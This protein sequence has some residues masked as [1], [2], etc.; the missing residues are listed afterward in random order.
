MLLLCYQ[1]R[2][3]KENRWYSTRSLRVLEFIFA[4]LEEENLINELFSPTQHE[5]HGETET[6]G[7]RFIAS[8]IIAR[9]I[10]AIKRE[11]LM[12]SPA[13]TPELASLQCV[14]FSELPPAISDRARCYLHFLL[15]GLW[16]R[17]RWKLK[18]SHC[19]HV[20]PLSAACERRSE[21]RLRVQQNICPNTTHRLEISFSV[22]AKS[23]T[24]CAICACNWHWSWLFSVR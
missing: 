12:V 10:E 7:M 20:K 18:N 21:P 9:V 22:C 17:A 3:K 5:A 2:P 15:P 16:L 11:S 6:L 4:G 13:D 24:G 19:E 8:F 14:T 1:R 23:H